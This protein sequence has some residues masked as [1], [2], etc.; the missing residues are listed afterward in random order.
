MQ[1]S[2]SLSNSP[3]FL[4]NIKVVLFLY[5][6]SSGTLFSIKIIAEVLSTATDGQG[7]GRGE[8]RNS[9]IGLL[10]KIFKQFLLHDG[11]GF[12]TNW[13]AAKQVQH[14][15]WYILPGRWAGE[16]EEANA[17]Q[18]INTARFRILCKRAFHLGSCVYFCA[19]V[20]IPFKQYY[21]AMQVSI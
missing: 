18:S 16:R 14:A 17:S 11:P 5:L 19:H 15:A 7:K 1:E 12:M 10:S 13:V 6:E 2:K 4:K 3:D 21:N 9:G 20:L 8:K